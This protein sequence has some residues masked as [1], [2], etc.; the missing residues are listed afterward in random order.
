MT[1]A[2]LLILEGDA[3]GARYELSEGTAEIGRG[4]R[5]DYRIIDNEVSRRHAAIQFESDAYWLLDRNS[6]NGTFVNGIQVSRHE[7]KHGDRIHLGHTV[8]LFSHEKSVDESSSMLDD[9]I[10][11]V[12]DSGFGEE[13]AIVQAM[14]HTE[15]QPLANLRALYRITEAA[16]SP[17]M[18]QDEMLQRILDLTI[19]VVGADR[20]SVLLTNEDDEILPRIY[21]DRRADRPSGKM[22]ISSSIVHHVVQHGR[23]VVT[24]DAQHDTRFQSGKSIINAGIREAMCVPMQGHYKL[25]G[26]IYVDITSSQLDLEK[27]AKERQFTDEEL[28]LLVAIGRQAALAIEGLNFQNALVK[29]E[30]FAAM[31]QTI[32]V[33]SHHV[34]NILQ[35]IRGGSYLIDMGLN[36]SEESL[37]RNGW[38]IVERNQ[39]KIYHLVMD[40][41][42]FSKE[43]QPVLEHGDLNATVREVCELMRAR[44]VES[45]VE[46]SSQLGDLPATSF[47]A[48]AIHQAVLNIVSNALDAIEESED[49]AIHLQTDYDKVTDTLSISVTDNGP[50]IPESQLASIFNLFESTKGSRGTGLGLAVSQKII[51]EHGG[52]IEVENLPNN[53][54][55]FRLY[56]THIEDDQRAEQVGGATIVAE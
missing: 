49:G 40:M 45:G 8:L 39:N 36:K 3:Q 22:V 41:L 47:D 38:T 4:V 55:R 37:V 13:S 30:R 46:F 17:S 56:W 33:L 51:R 21:A 24:S 23:G 48:E 18:S 14:E 44:A 34:K 19:D 16:V 29:A 20:G 9:V 12:G 1:K 52:D 42:T 35:G 53:G 54:C 26:V 2:T 43:R 6:S 32:A 50:G 28:R 10:H 31:G 7:L 27:A 15:S 5:N 11:I 25:Q